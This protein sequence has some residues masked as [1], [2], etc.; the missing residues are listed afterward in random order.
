MWLYTSMMLIFYST[1]A[2]FFVMRRCIFMTFQMHMNHT[3]FECRLGI[4]RLAATG[5]HTMSTSRPKEDS[6]FAF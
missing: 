5:H 6:N 3:V 2:M 4:C 1:P